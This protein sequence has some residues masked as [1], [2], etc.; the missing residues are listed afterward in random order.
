M[1]TVPMLKENELIGAIGI[2]RQEVRPFTDKQIELVTNF[3]AQA[4][5]A[6]ENTR[7]LNELRESLQQQTA[8]ADVLKVISRSTFDLQT[9]LDTLVE[10]A[11]RLCE[12][13]MAESS[14]RK[15]DTYQH[16]A[17]YGY[18]PEHA[19]H[20]GD[21][22]FRRARSVDGRREPARRQSRTYSRRPRRSGI[23]LDRDTADAR[24]SHHA[25]R[26]AAARRTCQ[27]ASSSCS[28]RP[29]DRSPKSRSSW[30]TTFADQ[31][32]IAIENVRLFDEVQARTR[33]LSEALEQQTATSEVLSVI[34][35]SPGEL[36][37]VFQAM[38]A[39]A[40]RI[41]EA[42]F[43]NLSLRGW[44]IPARCVHG[45]PPAWAELRRREPVFP[46]IPE[47][48]HGVLAR[49]KQVVHIE[50]IMARA[51]CTRERRAR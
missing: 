47:V 42:K 23:H 5:I 26:S 14:V 1:L 48:P 12:A 40:T 34:S 45:A 22:P 36:E 32:V 21:N 20:H 29:C 17:S 8:T 41:C 46:P 11:A 6:I 13:D 30:S 35:S 2:Y 44:R 10:S 37:P 38:L 28:A 31:A 39:N 18:T 49:T 19:E 3:A 33:E 50:D 4:V 27:S 43:G 25:R 9:V 7:L 15:G 51:G 24:L 16:V